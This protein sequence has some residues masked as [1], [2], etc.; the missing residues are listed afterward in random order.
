M[1]DDAASTDPAQPALERRLATILSC[2]VAGYTRLMGA[3]EEATVQAL[4][5][6]RAV[7]DAL[8]KQHRGR[9]FNTAG[10]AILAEFPSAVD[11]VRC[12]TEIQAALQTRNAHLPP[13]Q[14]MLF[15]MGI[16][17][18]DV[19]VQDGDL[20]GDGVNVASRIQ[21]VAEPGGICISGSVYDQIQN[22]LSLQFKPLG[23]QS[24][25]NVGQ[26]IR[27]FSITHGEAGALPAGAQRAN[28]KAIAFAA[29]AT[30][31]ASA[32]AAGGYALYRE[33]EAK[34]GEQAA[35]TAQLA[36]ERQA[37]EE[38]RRKAEEQSRRAAEA[39][40]KAERER[41]VAESTKREAAL[42][43]QLKSAEGAR[44]RAES[45]RR[46]L[47]DE[48]QRAEE[49]K[50]ATEARAAEA[51]AAEEKRA[52]DARMQ[53]PKKKR[54][55]V[56]VASLEPAKAAPGGPNRTAAAGANPFDGA[57]TGQICNTPNDPSK[58]VCWPVPL[59]VQNGAGTGTWER[60][61]IGKSASVLVA[62]APDGTATA[63]LDGWKAKGDEPLTGTL[64]GHAANNRVDLEGRWA[65]GL[66][67]EAHWTRKH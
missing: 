39:E 64:S 61:L 21:T 46:R 11:A 30:I 65:S 10:D 50:R 62:I 14:K 24:F 28:R 59:K 44:A 53:E 57:Y 22:K 32:L 48:R 49:Q 25:K 63:T 34:R 41:L 66:H 5:G 38:A 2:D 26:P 1:S 56:A 33:N 47:D 55:A 15:R 6:H 35:L 54:G 29:V 17:L 60:R 18:G 45:D 27:T 52:A 23:D 42:Q 58:K 16:N 51:R 12:A 37:T 40:G 67:V 36:A 8:L 9:V 4:R 7:F 13:E 20:L 31:V 19:V 3:N 43:A